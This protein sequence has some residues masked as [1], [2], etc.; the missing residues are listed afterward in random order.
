MQK[1]LGPSDVNC[2]LYRQPMS[3]VCHNCAWWAQIVRAL[4]RNTGEPADEWHCAVTQLLLM[5]FEVTNQLRQV[6]GTMQAFRTET[7]QTN[8]TAL[9]LGLG[10]KPSELQRGEVPKQLDQRQVYAL[11]S[12]NGKDDSS[13]TGEEQGKLL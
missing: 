6:D 9:A 4:N 8:I 7:T 10:V 5:Q 2:P 11:P 1:V 3:E 12:G 13:E